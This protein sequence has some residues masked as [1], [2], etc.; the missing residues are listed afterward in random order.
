MKILFTYIQ[1]LHQIGTNVE[2]VQKKKQLKTYNEM[3]HYD[4]QNG[5]YELIGKDFNLFA[6]TL[7]ELKL[8]ALTIHNIDILTILN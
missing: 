1:E 4:K 3:I 7:K 2:I 6:Y 5:F 8:Q